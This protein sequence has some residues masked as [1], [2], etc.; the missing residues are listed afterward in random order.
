[1]LKNTR[2]WQVQISQLVKIFLFVSKECKEQINSVFREG[3]DK[4][5]KGVYEGSNTELIS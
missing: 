3:K 1:V 4:G 5:I 2:N